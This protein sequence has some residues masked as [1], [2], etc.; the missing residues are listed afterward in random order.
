[1]IITRIGVDPAQPGIYHQ[2][3]SAL[4]TSAPVGYIAADRASNRALCLWTGSDGQGRA[5]SLHAGQGNWNDDEMA[6]ARPV[7]GYV[8]MSQQC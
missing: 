4:T 3:L 6:M 8:V 7:T 5:R 1:L 2:Q